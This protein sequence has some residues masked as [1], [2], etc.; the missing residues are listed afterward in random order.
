[1]KIRGRTWV[2]PDNVDTDQIISGKYLTI[3][4]PVEM[5]KHVF[6]TLKPGF[7]QLA[8]SGDIILAG[9]NFGSGS[10]REE[11]PVLL[12]R[13]GISLVIAQ[14]F[15]RLFFRNS[16]NIGLPVMECLDSRSRTE[17][18]DV[19]EADLGNGTVYNV[20]KSEAYKAAKLPIFLLNL[21]QAGGAVEAFRVTNANAKRL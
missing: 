8:Q 4:E 17:D 9:R 1:L 6:E 2:L 18:G 19:L 11:A 13:I 15:S 5:S 10:S 12:K 16:I 7:F 3:R 21:L 20:S 14:G